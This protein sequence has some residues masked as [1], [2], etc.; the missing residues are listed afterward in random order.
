MSAALFEEG[1]EVIRAL[2]TEGKVTFHGEFFDYDG[3]GFHSGTEMGPLRPLQTP[4]PIWV[5][6]NPR[7]KGDAPPEVIR[8]RLDAAT[9]R[10][11]L[12]GDGWMTC[13]RA[14]HPE[15]L[16]EQLYAIERAAGE[17]EVDCSRL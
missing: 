6:S 8:R 10:I 2:W 13:C 17:L 9:R 7:L 14:E 12:Y 5:V 3:V 15:E 4:P 11:L 16:V 1:L